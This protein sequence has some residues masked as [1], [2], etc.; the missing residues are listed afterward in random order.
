MCLR[1]YLK[2]RLL[3]VTGPCQNLEQQQG[4]VEPVGICTGLCP[5]IFWVEG[6]IPFVP[7]YLGISEQ[8]HHAFQYDFIALISVL[9]ACRIA[10]N[11]F[12][13]NHRAKSGVSWL[14][15]RT[16]ET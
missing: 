11:V 5:P 16:T 15:I 13:Q 6:H 3:F 8:V 2:K 7:R 10:I 12:G 1:F 9:D 4:P 14:Q